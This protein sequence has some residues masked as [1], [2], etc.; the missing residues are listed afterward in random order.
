[1]DIMMSE[2]EYGEYII[3]GDTLTLNSENNTAEYKYEIL[4]AIDELS[5]SVGLHATKS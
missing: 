1:M 4:L 3:K 5:R 2:P